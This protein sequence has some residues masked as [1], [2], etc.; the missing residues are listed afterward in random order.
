M[1]QVILTILTVVCLWVSFLSAGI[2]LCMQ[3]GPITE[4]LSRATALV[5]TA[6]FSRD[7]LVSMA[8]ITREYVI[9]E[10]DKNDIYKSIEQINKEANTPYKDKEGSD[11]AAVPDEYSLDANSISHLED[12]QSLFANVRIAFGICSFGAFG[13]LILLLVLCGRSACGK[14]L[15][16]AGGFLIL[17]L[18]AMGIWAA[19]DFGGM[20]NWLHSLFFKGGSWLFSEKSLMISMYPTAFW[21]GMCI[22]CVL[23]SAVLSILALIIGKIIK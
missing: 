13:F 9:K 6:K 20:F 8:T 3:Y 21:V 1:K 23:T 17:A 16:R 19:L 10:L 12:V 18:I 15:A 7:Q 4:N 22:I 14:A 11:F 5:D 2:V